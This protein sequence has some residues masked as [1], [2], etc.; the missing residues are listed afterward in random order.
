MASMPSAASKAA[1]S[2]AADAGH[3]MKTQQR[4]GPMQ[5]CPFL[6]LYPDLPPLSLSPSLSL[7]LSLSLSLYSLSLSLSSCFGTS[8]MQTAEL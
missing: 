5:G 2:K 1:A 3:G 4:V 7:A 8:P 6:I